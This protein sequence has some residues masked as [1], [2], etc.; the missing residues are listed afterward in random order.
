ML[1]KGLLNAEAIIEGC[2]KALLA[3]GERAKPEWVETLNSTASTLEDMKGKFF[4]KT[5]F[6]I[7][8]TNALLKD[9]NGAQS[10]AM[11]G[12][13]Y[14]M[15]EVITKVKTGLE[16]LVQRGKMDGVSLT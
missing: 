15:A 13:L 12:D 6:A 5:N 10:I 9:V 16:N 7:P 1:P 11:S 8:V 3:L 2:K 14:G 4:L